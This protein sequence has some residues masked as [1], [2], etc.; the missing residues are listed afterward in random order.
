MRYGLMESFYMHHSD[1]QYGV[2][3]SD[4][5]ELFTK[6]QQLGFDGIEFGLNRDFA[7]DPLWTGKGGLRQAMREASLET[8][9]EARSLCLHL[10]NYEEYSPASVHAAHRTTGRTV[11]EAALSACSEIGASVILVP[12]FGTGSLRTP[13]QIDYLVTEMRYLAETAESL[14]IRLGLETS[15]DASSVLAILE[16]IASEAVGVYF[17]VANTAGLDHE[18]V[19]EIRDLGSQIV[20]VHIKEHPRSPVLGSGEIDFSQ[21]ARALHLIGY[22][23][24]LVVEQPTSAD[25]V[26]QAN[27]SYLKRMMGRQD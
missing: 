18:V 7:Q 17:D 15:L 21:V 13:D 22:D 16:R 3:C 25:A 27:L 11:L 1:S 23:G 6:A 20:Q 12:F 4:R 24:Y 10:F 2:A 5:V 14:G 19:Q 26:T 9:V 8:G